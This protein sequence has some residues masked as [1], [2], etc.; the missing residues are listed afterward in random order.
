MHALVSALTVVVAVILLQS[1]HRGLHA[2]DVAD[3]QSR[4]VEQVLGRVSVLAVAVLRQQVRQLQEAILRLLASVE[5]GAEL[6]Q[7]EARL[8]AETLSA[9]VA[10][11]TERTGKQK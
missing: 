2:L 6:G 8:G 10:V 3:G 7:G 5:L 4:S 11:V 1:L 9:N